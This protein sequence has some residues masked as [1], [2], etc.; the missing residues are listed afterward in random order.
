MDL[1]YIDP[2]GEELAVKFIQEYLELLKERKSLQ[3]DIASLRRKFN[4]EGL[5]VRQVL[6]AFNAVKSEKKDNPELL[7]M[8]DSYKEIL[9]GADD[10]QRRLLELEN[11]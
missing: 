11:M 7:R 3:R 4:E 8:I 1:Y 9:K 10:V 2:D 5:P 6:R